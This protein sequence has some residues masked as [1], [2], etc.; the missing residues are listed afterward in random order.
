M[1]LKKISKTKN[2]NKKNIIKNINITKKTKIFLTYFIIFLILITLISNTK[3]YNEYNKINI[4]NKIKN[5][6]IKLEYPKSFENNNIKKLTPKDRI[7]EEQI[8][9]YD[10]KIIIELKNAEWSK[11]ENTNSM[12]PF[13]DENSNAIQIKPKS[14]EELQVGDIISYEYNITENGETKTITIIHRIIKI[15]KD[16]N[17]WYAITKGDNNKKED[18]KVRFS[19]I[20]RVLVAVIY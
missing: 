3:E 12:M 19:Q 20:K 15:G 17:G 2:K 16:E 4:K 1:K 10:D 5:N 18:E 11:F 9:I 8:K 6:I 14:E 7:K 13:L